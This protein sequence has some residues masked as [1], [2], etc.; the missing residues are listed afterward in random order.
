MSNGTAAHALVVVVQIVTVSVFTVVPT[1]PKVI[2]VSE[3]WPPE[4]HGSEG[5]SWYEAGA[6]LKVLVHVGQHDVVLLS[7]AMLGVIRHDRSGRTTR[8]GRVG[9]VG[10]GIM[11]EVWILLLEVVLCAGGGFF[12]LML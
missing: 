5:K 7:P 9:R 4:G 11:W 2:P 10:R 6:M 3:M 12:F 1:L 8:R